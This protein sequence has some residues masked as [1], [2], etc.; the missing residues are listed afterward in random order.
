MYK[1]AIELL[2]KINDEG[3]EAYIVGG[4]PRDLYLNRESIDI[5]ICTS[6]TPKELKDIFGDIMLPTVNYGSVTVVL[7]DVRFEITTFRR[8]LKYE[9]NRTPLEVEYIDDL[10]EDLK[11]RDF[12]INTLCMDKEGTIIDLLDG[13][14]DI[15]NKIIRM[16]GNPKDR[17]I[18]DALRILRAIRFAVILD[19]KIDDELKKYIKEYGY[20]L[21]NLSYDRKKEELDKI[22]T[23][24]NVAYGVSLIKELDL[25]NHLELNNIDTLTI[26]DYPIGIW[27]QL[28]V[29]DK[30]RFNK[31][32][33]D[34]IEKINELKDENI[35][36][37]DIL[38]KY[39][40]YIASIAGDIKGID[41]KIVTA[42][43]NALP[44]KSMV[45]IAIEPNHIIE[46]L[47][48]GTGPFVKEILV[49]LEYKILHG[50]LEN[51]L[52]TLEKY[53]L[54]NYK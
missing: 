6:A 28:D 23:S 46:I 7:N 41:R 38:Y 10:N 25:A 14:K 50:D 9:N 21:K 22:F 33:Y 19:F 48:R 34:T 11:R 2:K 30:Y 40:L 47:N 49:D 18:E 52:E 36:D 31:N 32:D 43:Y 12:T 53:V 16:V 5:D 29:L 17:L 13:K 1:T 27:A 44:I 3:F 35:L 39:G 24:P 4:Y 45:D 26:T 37:V 54:K 20:L 15:D 51:N 42:S 8:D